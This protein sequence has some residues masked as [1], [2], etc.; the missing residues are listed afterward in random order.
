MTLPVVKIQ[1]FSTHDGPGIR[2]T[3]FLKGCPLTCWWCHNPETA[4]SATSTVHNMTISEILNE[5]IKDSAFYGTNGGLTI[6]GG[7]PLYHNAAIELLHEAKQ[8]NLHVV[9][10]TSGF[11][12]KSMLNPLLAADLVQWDIK[13]T[14]NARHLQNTGKENTPSINNLRAFD[15]MGGKTELRCLLISNVNI[16]EDHI[17]KIAQLYKELNNCTGVTFLPC[18]GYSESKYRELGMPWQM[19]RE[20]IP[21]AEMMT[22][23]RELFAALA[24]S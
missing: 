6:S 4:T 22:W 21:I 3:L 2:T 1:R 17:G 13:D 9:I 14:N 8:R 12:E 15:A 20:H 7:E 18:H 10:Q 19:T 16:N 5:A 11:F 23:A 24:A